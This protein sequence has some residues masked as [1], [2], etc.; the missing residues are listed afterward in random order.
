MTCKCSVAIKKT[1][2]A[3][4]DPSARQST[5]ERSSPGATCPETT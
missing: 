1:S 4:D 2:V 5:P 3:G